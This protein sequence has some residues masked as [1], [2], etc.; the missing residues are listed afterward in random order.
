MISVVD[1]TEQRC[2]RAY[3]GPTHGSDDAFEGAGVVRELV[4]G[5]DELRQMVQRRIAYGR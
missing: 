1:F 3:I 5:R 4:G 2:R